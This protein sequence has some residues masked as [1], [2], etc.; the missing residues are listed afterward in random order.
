MA[1]LLKML[2]ISSFV[3][4]VSGTGIALGKGLTQRLSQGLSVYAQNGSSHLVKASPQTESSATPTP[5][6]TVTQQERYANIELFTHVLHFI[7]SGYVDEVKNKTL[8]EGAIK[9]MLETLDPHSNFLSAELY[10]EMQTDTSGKF[11]GLGI[12]IGMKDNILTIL[13]PIEDTPA[14]KA[15]IKPNDRIVKINGEST[16][17][18]NLVEAVTKMR[19]KPKT[20]VNI[21]IYR[22]GFDKLKDISITREIIHIQAVKNELLEPQYGYLRLTTFNENAASD[23][24]KAIEHMNHPEKMRGLVLDLRTNPGG[25]LEQAVDVTSLFI[26]E[27]VVVS[28]IGRNRDQTEVKHARKGK[29]F[30]D[31]PLAILV[32]SSTASAAEIVAGALQDHHRAIVLGQPTFGKGSVQTVIAL[33]PD[34]ALKLTIARYY[35]PSGR[36]IQEK[37]VQPDVILDEYDPRLLTQAKL[38]GESFRERDL[39]GHMI[40]TDEEAKGKRPEFKKDELDALTKESHDKRR[41]INGV[42]A[43]GSSKE[44]GRESKEDEEMTPY[45]LNPKEDFQVKQALIALKSLEVLKQNSLE[46]A[47]H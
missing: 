9:G 30:K 26:D 14:W 24:K 25:L 39:K 5:G 37:G 28:T 13:A 7:E 17:G 15:G 23:V 10:K 2:A 33:P 11:G 20:N 46:S 19:G 29:A 8:I 31:I 47:H 3:L 42:N 4:C 32:N 21:S 34:M 36:S 18:M 6:S 38:K 45:R 35:T 40:N 16:K 27:G 44:G 12:E 41:G 1:Q 43:P 22:E